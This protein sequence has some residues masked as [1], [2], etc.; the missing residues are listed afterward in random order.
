MESELLPSWGQVWSHRSAHGEGHGCSTLR[1]AKVRT[2]EDNIPQ[3]YSGSGTCVET[4]EPPRVAYKQFTGRSSES[5]P[6]P[7]SQTHPQALRHRLLIPRVRGGSYLLGTESLATP[8]LPPTETT[9]DG[10]FRSKAEEEEMIL[11]GQYK[12]FG[13]GTGL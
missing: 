11:K 4:A 6:Q 7:W 1:E 12:K 9:S 10:Q 13:R 5:R 8:V 2:A 3:P